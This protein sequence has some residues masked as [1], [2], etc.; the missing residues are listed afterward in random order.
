MVEIPETKKEEIEK[1][2]PI[3]TV[4]P[5]IVCDKCSNTMIPIQMGE[6]EGDIVIAHSNFEEI[7]LLGSL[8]HDQVIAEIQKELKQLAKK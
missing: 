4:F 1:A 6:N 8:K 7:M 3:G 2:A 5:A